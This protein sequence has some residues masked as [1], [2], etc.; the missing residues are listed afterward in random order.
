MNATQKT[1]G[2]RAIE[3]LERSSNWLAK[4]NEYEEKGNHSKAEEC[5]AKS[6]SWLMRS[7]KLIGDG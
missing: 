3:A 5:F 4:G 1:E 6:A 2:V 7:N